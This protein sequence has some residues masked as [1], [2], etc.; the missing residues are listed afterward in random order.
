[1]YIVAIYDIMADVAAMRS[2]L[3]QASFATHSLDVVVVFV[4]L[5]DNVV[6]TAVMLLRLLISVGW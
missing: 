2:V 5:I 6:G 1:M 3:L 4:A